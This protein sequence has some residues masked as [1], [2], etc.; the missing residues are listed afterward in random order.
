M[1]SFVSLIARDWVVRR[2]LELGLAELAVTSSETASVHQNVGSDLTLRHRKMIS[3]LSLTSS[4]LPYQSKIFL[5]L[6]KF[7]DQLVNSFEGECHVGP[8]D[9]LKLQHV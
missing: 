5:Q 8:M 2:N 7:G 3:I 6:C 1:E 9:E 4:S